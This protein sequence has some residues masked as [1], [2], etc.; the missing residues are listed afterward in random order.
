MNEEKLIINAELYEEEESYIL[1]LLENDELASLRYWLSQ[2]IEDSDLAQEEFNY[3]DAEWQYLEERKN[4]LRT[5][6][7]M[8]IHLIEQDELLEQSNIVYGWD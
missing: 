5:I 6:E 1:Q 7:D 2:K 3:S 4:L 8:V